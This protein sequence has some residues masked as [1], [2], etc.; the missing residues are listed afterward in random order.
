MSIPPGSHPPYGTPPGAY[1]QPPPPPKKSNTALWVLLAVFG[2]IILLCGGC[3][4]AALAGFSDDPSPTVPETRRT[5]AVAA[6]PTTP[7]AAAPATPAAP[8][9]NPGSTRSPKCQPVPDQYVA[10]IDGSF[11]DSSQSL[12]NFWAIPGPDDQ[13]WISG[14]IMEGDKK[15]HSA[16]VWVA[17]GPAVFSLSGSARRTSTLPDGRDALGLSAGDDLGIE[18]QNCATS[19]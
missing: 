13:L 16:A 17:D 2:G 6:A 18:V 19:R 15:I 12:A 14:N 10:I 4:L 1:G 11:S 9:F 3:G 7:A 5:T 8:E